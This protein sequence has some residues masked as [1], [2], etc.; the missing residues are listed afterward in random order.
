M[1][2]SSPISS[3]QAARYYRHYRKENAKDYYIEGD[4]EGEWVGKAAAELGLDGGVTARDFK[5]V[6]DGRHPASGIELVRGSS[7]RDG[8]RVAAWDVTFAAPKSV[9]LAA[10]IGR[11]ESVVRA[12][13]EATRE[14]V[15]AL[16]RLSRGR[17]VG[18][19]RGDLTGNVAVALFRHETSRDLDPHLHTHSVFVNMTKN[20]D[21]RWVALDST[22]LFELQRYGTTIYRNAL[23]ERLI[24]A[25]YELRQGPRGAIEIEGITD[26][27]IAHFSKRHEA[28]WAVLRERGQSDPEAQQRVQRSTRRRKENVHRADLTLS[29]ERASR[30]IGLDASTSRHRRAPRRDRTSPS[31]RAREAVAYAIAHVTEREAVVATSDIVEAALERRLGYVS[32]DEAVREIERRVARREL[33]PNR[34][35]RGYLTTRE[36]L[37][38]ERAILRHLDEATGTVTPICREP[39][40]GDVLALRVSGGGRPC[41]A[42]FDRSARRNS[43]GRRSRE[44]LHARGREIGGRTRGA[45]RTGIRA[46]HWRDP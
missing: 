42:S 13:D 15:R 33:I 20:A 8:K 36:M 5:A 38:L 22:M 37:T 26:E 43:R 23:A 1:T 17:V 6:L 25:G 10:L 32:E 45:R 39:E 16:E 7:A 2:T 19:R 34:E 27:Q 24:A 18:R 31:E 44:D 3:G 40:F 14:A 4:V 41:G 12:H 21:G 30:E 11:D 35:H 46:D 9:S 28:I 29:W